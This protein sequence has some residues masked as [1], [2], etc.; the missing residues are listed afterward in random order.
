M[1]IKIYRLDSVKITIIMILKLKDFSYKYILA[2]K[3]NVL[4]TVHLEYKR[5]NLILSNEFNFIVYSIHTFQTLTMTIK[6]RKSMSYRSGYF[7]KHKPTFDI[8][9]F[10]P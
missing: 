2:R 5:E 10:N 6:P 9:I 1:K 8:Y 7:H 4:V 3:D